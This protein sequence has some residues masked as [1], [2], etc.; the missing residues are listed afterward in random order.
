VR[1]SRRLLLTLG[2]LGCSSGGIETISIGEVRVCRDPRPPAELPALQPDAHRTAFFSTHPLPQLVTAGGPVLRNP[3]IVAVFLGDDPLR[4]PT[5]ALLRSYGCTPAW[6]EAVAEYGVGDAVF[7]RSIVLPAAPDVTGVAAFET[8]MRQQAGALGLRGEERVFVFFPP[9]GF[10]VPDQPCQGSMGFHAS[11]TLETSDDVVVYAVINR[12]PGP[13]WTTP[14]DLRAHTTT[15]ELME[16]AVN[17]FPTSDP[18]WNGLDHAGF[19]VVSA[20]TENADLCNDLQAYTPDYPFPVASGWSNR[21]ARAGFDPCAPPEPG[22]PIG[23][24]ASRRSPIDLGNGATEVDV[25]LDFFAEDPTTRF[26]WFALIDSNHCLKL[27]PK[28]GP[29]SDTFGDGETQ[30]LTLIR[31]DDAGCAGQGT[32]GVD[33]LFIDVAKVTGRVLRD[34]TVPIVGLPP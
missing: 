4:E 13:L 32:A 8:W 25:D 15:H 16:M 19:D 11:M 7:E 2:L 10:P 29:L 17:P 26:R 31:Q 23:V 33:R 27:V 5:E 3:R 24:A 22:R 30:H 18:A 21:R 1:W 20:G 9:A 34:I 14:L 12:C 28:D 6:H